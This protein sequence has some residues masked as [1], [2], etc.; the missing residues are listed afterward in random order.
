[1][2]SELREEL[3]IWEE[4]LGD[5]RLLGLIESRPE[6]KPELLYHL[7]CRLSSARLA[8]RARGARDRGEYVELRFAP[9]GGDELAAWR[10][11]R[12]DRLAVPS[13]ALCQRLEN[14]ESSG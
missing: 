7:S 13:R 6:G 10:R 5:P 9:P 8:S 4:D 12:E 11:E 14:P 1:M 3:D 2:L